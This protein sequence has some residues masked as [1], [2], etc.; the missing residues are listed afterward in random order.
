MHNVYTCIILCIYNYRAHAVLSMYN[1]VAIDVDP[2]THVDVGVVY[3]TPK[4][5]SVLSNIA[6]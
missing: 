2:I 3:A 5:Y 4:S 1:T 6:I